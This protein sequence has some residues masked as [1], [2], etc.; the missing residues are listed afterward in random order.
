MDGA[1]ARIDRQGIEIL[2]GSF[3]KQSGGDELHV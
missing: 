3:M 1:Q 2:P